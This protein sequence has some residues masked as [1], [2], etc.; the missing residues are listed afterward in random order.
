M[1]DWR[2]RNYSKATRVRHDALVDIVNAV[3]PTTC[4]SIFYVAVTR[5]VPGITK[6]DSG[7][8]KI[9]SDLKDLRYE[10]RISWNSIRDSVRSAGYWGG[11]AD[12]GEYLQAMAG[13]YRR[14]PWLHQPEWVEVWCESRSIASI[15]ADTCRDLAVRAPLTAFSGNPSLTL[16]YEQSA[17]INRRFAANDG[18]ETVILY[19]GDFDPSGLDIDRQVERDLGYWCTPGSWSFERIGVTDAMRSTLTA[20]PSPVKPRDA[21]SKAYLADWG[22]VAFECEAIPP[23][24]MR[25]LVRD[26]VHALID[27]AAWA[28]DVAAE[29]KERA[30]LLRLA[31][32]F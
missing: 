15:V 8:D 21:R 28:E 9:L 31:R 13:T 19:L 6:D 16:T 10:G 11:S 7:Y 2:S 20:F 32:E 12:A 22:P 18:Q 27:E 17:E 24:E 30:R 1:G 4:R 23:P 14:N 29:A 25:A 3:Q 5:G 26:K